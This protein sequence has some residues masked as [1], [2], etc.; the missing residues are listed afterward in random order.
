MRGGVDGW[1]VV[2]SDASNLCA[3]DV[4]PCDVGVDAG[5]VA[6]ASF[7]FRCVK[8]DCDGAI[9]PNGARHAG[10]DLAFGA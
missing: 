3:V 5:R 1:F 6:L 8:M 7:G 10:Q 2:V 9:A 4:A